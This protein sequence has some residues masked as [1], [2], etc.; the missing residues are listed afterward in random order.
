MVDLTS[1]WY[2]LA[3]FEVLL[4]SSYTVITYLYSRRNN[5]LPKTEKLPSI[6]LI[7]PMFNEEKVIQEKI[8]NTAKLDYPE[9]KLNV[10]LLDDHSTDDSKNISIR[11]IE[12]ES[13]NAKVIESKGEKGKARALNWL[14]PSLETDITVISDADALLKENSLLQ[15]SRNFTDPEVGGV[16]GKIVI[17][18]DRERISKSQ[19][20][21]YRFF[22]DIWRLG[23]SNIQSVSICNGPLMGFRTDRACPTITR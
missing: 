4:F 2:L 10:I 13:L 11:V 14:F 18:S 5:Q 1:F 12:E 8:E 21:S 22:F 23:E 15:I 9:E 20:D 19:E 6:T 3:S 7:I 17:A 16:T